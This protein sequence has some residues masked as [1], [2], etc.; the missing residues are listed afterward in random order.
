MKIEIIIH[1]PS[2]ETKRYLVHKLILH[3]ETYTAHYHTVKSG[4]RVGKK[5]PV[6]NVAATLEIK[7]D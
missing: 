4:L 5:I 1:H 7:N 3:G 6:D 2:G